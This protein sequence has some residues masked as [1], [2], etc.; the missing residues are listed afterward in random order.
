M[1]TERL[2]ITVSVD[3][4]IDRVYALAALRSV[5]EDPETRLMPLL[6]VAERPALVLLVN[7]AYA[8]LL[9]RLLPYVAESTAPSESD[10]PM[11]ITLRAGL[12][13]DGAVA[14][15]VSRR[16]ERILAAMTL[17]LVFAVR[18]GEVSSAY[19]DEA[20]RLTDALKDLIG[21]GQGSVGRL[22]S[23]WI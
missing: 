22:T 6:T 16:I 20:M 10:R 9:L 19:D 23:C 1:S 13:A 5:T 21:R 3:A 2:T 8:Q 12:V 18:S 4:V 15:A 7:D 17:A 11:A 14:I